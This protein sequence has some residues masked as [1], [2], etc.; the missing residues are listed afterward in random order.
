M[1]K[2]WSSQKKDERRGG[3]GLRATKQLYDFVPLWVALNLQR[4]SG[5]DNYYPSTCMNFNY[6]CLLMSAVSRSLAAKH[7]PM[8]TVCIIC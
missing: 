1:G 7:L 4:R 3:W 6:P 5:D 8:L 2:K